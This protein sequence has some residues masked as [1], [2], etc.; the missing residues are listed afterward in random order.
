[1]SELMQRA[2]AVVEQLQGLIHEC[3]EVLG[4]PSVR[5]TQATLRAVDDVVSRLD[6]NGV[7]VAEDLRG[8]RNRL[9]GQMAVVEE[10]EAVLAMLSLEVPQPATRQRQA[11]GA[12]PASP[13]RRTR[14]GTPAEVLQQ[15][16]TEALTVLGGRA[17]SRQ[18]Q[19]WIRNVHSDDLAPEDLETNPRGDPRWIDRLHHARLNMVRSGALRGDSPTTVWELP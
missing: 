17:T 13:R 8:L 14:D 12:R 19:E 10:A 11:S 1:V 18:V 6:A 4:N 16:L 15:W 2:Q 3:T 9:V 5:E 7:P